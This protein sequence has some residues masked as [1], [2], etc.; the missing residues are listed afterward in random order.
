MTVGYIVVNE[1]EIALELVEGVLWMGMTVTLFPNYEMARKAMRRTRTY[2]I[3]NRYE[4]GR[5]NS[6]RRVTSV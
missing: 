4:W 5:E 1:N 3:R 2:A 6:I